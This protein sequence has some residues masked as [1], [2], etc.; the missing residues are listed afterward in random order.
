MSCKSYISEILKSENL[1]VPKL[2]KSLGV[3]PSTVLDLLHKD[4]FYIPSANMLSK[5]SKH[6]NKEI[7]AILLEMFYDVVDIS[8]TDE[9][10]VYLVSLFERDYSISLIRTKAKGIL[11]GTVYQFS[12]EAHMKRTNIHYRID[13]WSHLQEEYLFAFPNGDSK[14]ANSFSD[15][16]SKC[17][18]LLCF[19]CQKFKCYTKQSKSSLQYSYKII[20]SQQEEDDYHEVSTLIETLGLKYVKAVMPDCKILNEVQV[21]PRKRDKQECGL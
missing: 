2:S 20:F 1:S 7:S 3:Y 13:T 11:P 10:L 6:L 18:S 16:Y 12:S 4:D 15:N 19:G 14:S 5:L 8:F 21:A 17:A 9:L